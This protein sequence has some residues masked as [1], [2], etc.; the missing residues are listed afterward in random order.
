MN[1][2]YIR[3]YACLGNAIIQIKNVIKIALFYRYNVIFE[4]FRHFMDKK[5]L[6][7]NENIKESFPQITNKHNFYHQS[8][9]NTDLTLYNQNLDTTYY[10]IRGLF[11]FNKLPVKLLGPNDLL[12]H[13]RS[14][15]IFSAIVPHPE[16]IMPPLEYYVNIIENNN[17]SKIYLVA[18]D[19]LNPCIN[20]LLKLYP[21]IIFTVQSL[22]KDLKLILGAR[23]IV[24]SYGTFIPE[25]LTFSNECKTLYTPDYSTRYVKEN[26]YIA[27]INVK[28]TKLSNYKKLLTPWKNVASQK[29]YMLNYSLKQEEEPIID[30]IKFIVTPN[31]H[32]QKQ[33]K[34]KQ[35][36]KQKQLKLKQHKK[37]IQKKI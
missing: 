4:P 27:K 5:Y 6:V 37:L 13:I 25:V 30:K 9:N 10:L 12:I 2:L 16:Y 3:N 36:R 33:Q 34:R 17:Y 21:N 1:N 24:M 15:D 20:K 18:Q 22:E 8:L 29:E 11:N 32:K 14:G 19:R 35:I 28:I 31:E 7:I 23:N 26:I